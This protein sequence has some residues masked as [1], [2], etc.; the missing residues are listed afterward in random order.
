MCCPQIENPSNEII[1]EWSEKFRGAMAALKAATEELVVEGR[2]GSM[3]TEVDSP[4]AV[5]KAQRDK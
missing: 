5:L 4:R 2:E 3:F 1:F